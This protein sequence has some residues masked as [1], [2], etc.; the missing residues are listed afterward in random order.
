MPGD[1]LYEA[2]EFIL[3][4]ASED[5]LEVVR[6]ALKRRIE[7]SDA[8]GPMGLNPARL[9]R[10]TA[11]SVQR[12]LGGSRGS[13]REMVRRFAVEI[14]RKEAPQ[15]T[16]EQVQALLESWVPDQGGGP[17]AG[18]GGAGALPTSEAGE[19]GEA[20]RGN[21]SP[22]GSGPRTDKGLPAKAVVTMI[23]QFVAYSTESMP[24]SE[25]VKLRDG[26][27]DWQRKYWERFSPRVRELISLFLSG[28]LDKESFW[29]RIYGELGI[30]PSAG[31]G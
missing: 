24:V 31:R 2:I 20:L 9:A 12:Q 16:D 21:R 1:R 18:G 26:I 25:Q 6:A 28:S 17:E 13:I 23:T 29:E 14:I 22:R 30:D 4:E 11:A 10:E 15:L 5:E 8:R 7:G 27:G 3:N 19:P